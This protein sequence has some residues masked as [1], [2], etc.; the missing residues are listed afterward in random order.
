MSAQAVVGAKLPGV[1]TVNNVNLNLFSHF[2]VARML[3]IER[4]RPRFKTQTSYSMSL[5]FTFLGFNRKN[6]P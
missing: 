5:A 3:V 6:K 4:E 1:L 2:I